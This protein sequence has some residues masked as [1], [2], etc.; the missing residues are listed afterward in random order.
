MFHHRYP[1]KETANELCRLHYNTDVPT[2]STQ[3]A[4]LQQK[5]QRRDEDLRTRS[6]ELKD[7]RKLSRRLLSENYSLRGQLEAAENR[8]RHLVRERLRW[9]H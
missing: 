6:Q 4:H 9:L 7:S 2:L 1:S 8:I 5:L 3:V